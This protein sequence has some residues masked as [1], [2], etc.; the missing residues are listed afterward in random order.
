[1][2]RRLGANVGSTGHECRLDRARM[3]ARPGGSVGSTGG[4]KCRPA[5]V[6]W[7]LSRDLSSALVYEDPGRASAPARHCIIARS[8]RHL[9]PLDTAFSPGRRGIRARSTL[10]MRP[11]DG[12][13]APA[14]QDICARSTGVGRHGWRGAALELCHQPQGLG[15]RLPGRPQ[16]LVGN[17]APLRCR[18]AVPRHLGAGFGARRGRA[19]TIRTL[20]RHSDH[21]DDTAQPSP[22]RRVS[23]PT[24]LSP[25]RTRWP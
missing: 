16:P 25:S 6:C 21:A 22:C 11:V 1:M 19:S 2:S 9:R 5:G 10:H 20:P 7:Q 3:S 14:R 13:F 8:T 15:P 24:C 23:D 17:H 12:A 4:R 18:Y